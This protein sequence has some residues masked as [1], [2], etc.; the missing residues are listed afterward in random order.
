MTWLF[1]LKLK[2]LFLIYVHPKD[3]KS[4]CWNDVDESEYA[5]TEKSRIMLQVRTVLFSNEPTIK[6][7]WRCFIDIFHSQLWQ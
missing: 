7:D 2:C 5:C 1:Y 3:Y 4:D 6:I